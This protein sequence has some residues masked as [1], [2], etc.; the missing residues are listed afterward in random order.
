MEY[1]DSHIFKPTSSK[2]LDR[3][4]WGCRQCLLFLATEISGL[5]TCNIFLWDYVKDRVYVP[6]MPKTIEELKVRICYALA[7]VT[8]QMLQNVLREM[9][10]RCYGL[11]ADDA[12]VHL[13]ATA[14]S[15]IRVDCLAGM[16]TEGMKGLAGKSYYCLVNSVNNL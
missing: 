9:D 6:P 5:D 13:V 1:G 7:S 8:E 16:E 14:S 4:K 11:Y 3:S 10:Y 12:F 2:V 15:T